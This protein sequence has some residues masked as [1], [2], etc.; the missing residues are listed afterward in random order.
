MKKQAIRCKKILALA[1]NIYLLANTQGAIS[2]TL[3]HRFFEGGKSICGLK[4]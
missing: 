2:A 3:R 4:I 1:I